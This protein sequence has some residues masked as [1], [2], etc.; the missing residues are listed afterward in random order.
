MKKWEIHNNSKFIIK[1]AEFKE[2]MQI[3]LQNRGIKTKKEIE[4]FL[5]PTLKNI[6]PKNVGIDEKQLAKAL[7]RIEKAIHKK[8]QVI[9]FGDY[10]VDGITTTAILWEVLHSLGASVMPYIPHRID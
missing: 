6:T 4:E 2:L 8:E 9:I 3:I 1:N 7:K 10:D 5:N